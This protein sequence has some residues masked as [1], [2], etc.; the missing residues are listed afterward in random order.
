MTKAERIANKMIRDWVKLMSNPINRGPNYNPATFDAVNWVNT[1]LPIYYSRE[2]PAA[3]REK[4][5][6]LVKTLWAKLHP[7]LNL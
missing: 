5:K 3:S 1:R 6:Q 4:A 7:E 2:V